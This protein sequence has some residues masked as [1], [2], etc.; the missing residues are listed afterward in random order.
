MRFVNLTLKIVKM[1]KHFLTL[2]LFVGLYNS[3]AQS[4]LGY[5]NDNYS[6]VNGVLYNPAS[7]VGT[8]Y[9]AHI[10]L[11]SV[12]IAG[13]NDYFGVKAADLFKGSYDIKTD[14]KYFPSANNNFVVNADVMGPSFM[15]NL[16]PKHAIA[17]YSRVRGIANINNINGTVLNNL[18]KGL[19]TQSYDEKVGNF[20]ASAQEWA[21]LG[22]SYATVL[23]DKNNHFIKGGLTVK[24]L[25]GVLNNYAS[26]KDVTLKYAYDNATPNN[27]L[28]TTSG[29]LTYGGV[30]TGSLFS[31]NP[32]FDLKSRGN[33]VGADVGFVYEYRKDTEEDIKY[34]FRVGVSVTDI[35]SINYKDSEQKR[36]NLNNSKA[37]SLFNA[38][39]DLPGILKN[40]AGFAPINID[41]NTRVNLPTAFHGNIDVNI[42]KK[43]FIGANGDLSLINKNKLG[44]TSIANT[45]AITP[46]YESKW[47]GFYVPVTIME[48]RGTQVGAGFR[49]G[50]LFIGSGSVITNLVSKESKG[51][52]VHAGLFIPIFGGAKAKDSDGD[53]LLDKDDNCPDVAGPIENKGCPYADRD[54]DGIADKDDK[55]P[56]VAGPKEN[57]GCPLDDRDKDGVLDKDDKCPE[58]AGPRE[59]MGCPYKDRDKDGILDKD[60][61]CPDVP[62]TAANNGCPEAEKLVEKKEVKQDVVKKLN[63]FA[64]TILFD[65]G[66]SSIKKESYKVINQISD[67]MKEYPTSKFKLVGYTD[68]QGNATKNL[69]L[70]K[71]RAAEVRKYII[72]RGNDA[73]RLSSD[74]FGIKKPVASNKTPKGRALNRR[75]EVVLIK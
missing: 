23:L 14:A 9:K 59:N 34:K 71:D 33:G 7:I 39:N 8:P 3:N 66:K 55:C 27:S 15:L 20:N 30:T 13:A 49:A 31:R 52:D 57:R 44:A 24:Y 2:L 6:G 45:L 47:F 63:D 4:Y 1:K 43:F 10:N 37:A 35:G 58:V 50:P 68:N 40:V 29:E 41:D 36:Y 22:L 54:N 42:Y 70:S 56:N 32:Q 16:F 67:I 61:K 73:S 26:G 48:Y 74:G 51:F 19:N 5:F 11:A 60:D 12:S 53:G 62:G 65:T 21:E 25:Q 46:R 75:V 38:Q 17:I 18:Y 64:K 28:V 72:D 69:K